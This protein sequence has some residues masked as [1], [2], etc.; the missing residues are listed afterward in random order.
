MTD[1][2]GLDQVSY[3]GGSHYYITFIDVSTRKTWVYCIQNKYD[4]F[5]T[6]RNGKLWLI[7]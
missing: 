6:L 7:S 2:W 3:L 4:V 5:D 1:V